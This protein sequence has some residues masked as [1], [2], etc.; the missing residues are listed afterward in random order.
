LLGVAERFVEVLG[1]DLVAD[2]CGSGH[3]QLGLGGV[4]AVAAVSGREDKI[5]DIRD[6]RTTVR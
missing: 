2:G 4:T 5:Q 3:D 1:D 6:K